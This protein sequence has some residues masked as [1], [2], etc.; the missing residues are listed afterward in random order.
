MD[1]AAQETRIQRR[2]FIRLVGGGAVAGAVS[3]ANGRNCAELV[4]AP[5]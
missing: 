4:A 1:K 3:A 5:S 2:N